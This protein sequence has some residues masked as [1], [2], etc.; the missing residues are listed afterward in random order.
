MHEDDFAHDEAIVAEPGAGEVLVKTEWIGIDATVRTWLSKA[1]GYIPP[2]EIGEVVRSSGIGRVVTSRSDGIREGDLVATLTGWQEYAVVGDDP[3]LTTVLAEGTDPQAALGVF[4]ANGLTAYVGLTEIGKIQA[5]ETVVVSA[6]AGATGSIAVQIAKIYGCRVIGISGTAEKCG[7]LV[8]GLGLDGAINHRTD[9]IPAR[10]RELCPK[11]VDVFFD[12][13]GG[14]ILDC[15][16]GRLADHARVVLCGAISSYND[17]HK[18]PGPSNYLNLISRRA[19]MEGFIS[20]DSWGRY[21][22]IMD[23]LG[24]WVADGRLQ[25]RS[26]I[27]EGLESAPQALNAMFTGENIG[28]VIIRV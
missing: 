18:P 5:G 9:D 11:R 21:A 3:M 23:T 13:T 7:W 27:F 10:L 14:P 26:H 24:G 25:H 4:G 12:N 1:E 15:V 20:W 19:R 8:D 2:V 16:L 17:H 6:A 22:E 28:K